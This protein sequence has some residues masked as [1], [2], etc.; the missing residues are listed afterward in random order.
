MVS[1]THQ[2]L[3]CLLCVSSRRSIKASSTCLGLWYLFFSIQ[4]VTDVLSALSVCQ[5]SNSCYQYI[6]VLTTAT[7]WCYLL[8]FLM[9]SLSTVR[10]L[11]FVYILLNLVFVW[12]FLTT[13]M[14][15]NMS[16]SVT[17]YSMGE[18]YLWWSLNTLIFKGP[19]P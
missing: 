11:V 5:G 2:F 14:P 6:I 13:Y 12:D 17:L 18:H 3:W 8:L 19:S 7:L 1:H 4:K 16:L 9:G 15:V 10:T